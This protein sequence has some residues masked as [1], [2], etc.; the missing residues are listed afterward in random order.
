MSGDWNILGL[1]LIILLIVV[2][3]I[4]LRPIY[5][6]NKENNKIW[7]KVVYGWRDDWNETVE[8]GIRRRQMER[9]KVYKPTEDTTNPDPPTESGTGI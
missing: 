2:L 6:E 7:D 3:V 8:E 9:H 1:V 5:L 4:F